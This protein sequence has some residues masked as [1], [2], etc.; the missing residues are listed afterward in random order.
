M[1]RVISHPSG[2]MPQRGGKWLLRAP[3]RRNTYAVK[4]N[5]QNRQKW[6]SEF[7][8]TVPRAFQN[9]QIYLY[10]L[11]E[12]LANKLKM[13]STSKSQYSF[14]VEKYLEKSEKIY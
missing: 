2:K 8:K 6:K 1:R 11:A 3:F 7:Y 13:L 14:T 9:L 4:I 5:S 10:P 12:N